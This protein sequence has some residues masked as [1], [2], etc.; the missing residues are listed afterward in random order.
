VG[1]KG[2]NIMKKATKY[3]IFLVIAWNIHNIEEALTMSNWIGVNAT[4]F[5]FAKFIPVSIM[6]QSLPIALIITTL[7]LFIIPILAIYKRWD[8]RIFGIVLGICL[9]N[10]LG[11]I[12]TSVVFG[13][14]SPGVITASL[15][16]LPLSVFILRQL[17]KANLLKNFSWMHIF[18]YAIIVFVISISAIWILALS[19]N[20][21]NK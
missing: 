2:I 10:A 8:N 19:I 1:G 14:Y 3:W 5:P 20:Y 18:S 7:F 13:G 16:N 11:H 17:F 9:L 15:L 12:L 6:Q 21:L 4:K